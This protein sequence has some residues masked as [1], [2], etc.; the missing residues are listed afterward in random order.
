MNRNQTNTIAPETK[1]TRTIRKALSQWGF[2]P[3]AERI[4]SLKR[5]LDLDEQGDREIT[6]QRLYERIEEESPLTL[7]PFRQYAEPELDVVYLYVVCEEL[8]KRELEVGRQTVQELA[9][10]AKQDD[11]QKGF[12]DIDD[13]VQCALDRFVSN[14]WRT[15]VGFP[16]R[17][18]INDPEASSD[19]DGPSTDS[20]RNDPHVSDLS[21]SE[22][23]DDVLVSMTT[24]LVYVTPDDEDET[25]SVLSDKVP[26]ANDVQEIV[27]NLLDNLS[28]LR[29]SV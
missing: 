21:T 6:P 5:E 14:N 2:F 20:D 24:G 7:L 19:D 11:D 16:Q 8:K 17:L 10:W 27:T 26:S 9:Y 23:G 25:S 22:S 1:L 29:N 4:A 28:S 15:P 3:S 18:I 13:S 12:V